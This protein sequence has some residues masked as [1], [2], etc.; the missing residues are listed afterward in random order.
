[1]VDLVR[2]EIENK[3][4]RGIRDF[5]NRDLSGVNLSRLNLEG[6]NFE[7]ANLE[8]ANFERAK[9]QGADL[10]KANL[11]RAN[12]TLAHLEEAK[13][14]EANLQ[15]AYLKWAYLQEANLR[16][17][18]LQGANLLGANLQRANL[19][20]AN[21]SGATLVGAHLEGANLKWANL[22]GA[23]LQEANLQGAN[24]FRANLEGANL[25]EANLEGANLIKAKLQGANLE[26]AI[27]NKK[28]IFPENFDPL[29]AEV[30]YIK[31]VAQS[32]DINSEVAPKLPKFN[33]PELPNINQEQPLSLNKN[34]TEIVSEV[35]TKEE[36][37]K[38]TQVIQQPINAKVDELAQAYQ[39]LESQEDFT[40][41]SLKKAQER[42][43]ISIARRQGQY[44]FR[45]D[46]LKAYNHHCAITGCDAVEAL[47]AA[48]IIPYIETENN[49]P[50]NG[51][52][53]RADIHTLFDLNLITINPGTMTVQ[54][55]P[56]LGQS[57][58]KE[59]HGKLLQLP[60]N[61]ANWPKVEYLKWRCKQC[62]WYCKS[63]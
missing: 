25:K 8:G 18:K 1:M 39:Q 35:T 51:L 7:G 12:L 13:L 63:Q 58:Y 57:Y 17:A 50:S 41:K 10:F 56:S 2:N 38:I 19:L 26:N 33:N 62:E 37:Q 3:Y 43:T 48:H 49:H 27:A 61:P 45:Q 29:A 31:V 40:P 15:R 14:Q 32:E 42:I 55:S 47:E 52:L 34:V 28:T 20:G 44:Q 22:Q 5:S 9:L 59:F 30:R 36:T 60:I 46:L 53:L 4:A 16:F 21:L 54:I 6:A 23:E 11:F 24:L